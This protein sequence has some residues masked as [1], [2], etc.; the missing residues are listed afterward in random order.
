MSVVS[1]LSSIAAVK[2]RMGSFQRGSPDTRGLT[3]I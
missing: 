1:S 3:G 2:N